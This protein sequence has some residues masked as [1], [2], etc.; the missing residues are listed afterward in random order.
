MSGSLRL[1]TVAKR[2]LMSPGNPSP[3]VGLQHALDGLR[4]GD[5][6]CRRVALVNIGWPGELARGECSAG[7]RRL[8]K[9]RRFGWDRRNQLSEGRSS[10]G[11]RQ[12]TRRMK[13]RSITRAEVIMRMHGRFAPFQI[14]LGRS[15]TRL[16]DA[17]VPVLTAA[18]ISLIGEKLIVPIPPGH[19]LTLG[20]VSARLN[21]R[22]RHRPG[23]HTQREGQE[24][25]S[26]SGSTST[27][28]PAQPPRRA[29]TTKSQ[30]TASAASARAGVARARRRRPTGGLAAARLPLGP[31]GASRRRGD[32]RRPA[33]HEGGACAGHRLDNA[34]DAGQERRSPKADRGYRPTSAK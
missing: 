28:S 11:S 30:P 16:R 13:L 19:E 34:V 26:V 29:R 20:R 1:H 32:D 18:A 6:F 8:L 12:V 4:A 17:H 3:A 25:H 22:S 31:R 21:Q 7:E 23:G 14:E 9:R 15:A 5:G 24:W 27:P 33:S 2:G 10:A